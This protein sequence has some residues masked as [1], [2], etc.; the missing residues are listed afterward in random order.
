LICFIFLFVLFVLFVSFIFFSIIS[1][2]V[3]SPDTYRYGG[4]CI[5]HKCFKPVL[6]F[7]IKRGNSCFGT[8]LCT[9]HNKEF[10]SFACPLINECTIYCEHP[11]NCEKL[12][13]TINEN[14]FY[15]K[16]QCAMH[17]RLKK[18]PPLTRDYLPISSLIQLGKQLYKNQKIVQAI[19][20]EYFIKLYGTRGLRPL[21]SLPG[22]PTPELGASRPLV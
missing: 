13:A 5:L 15:L 18:I 17:Q 11:S 20:N 2:N 22:G 12:I 7:G 9:S 19:E 10:V 21:S 6:N 8:E 14:Y 16:N 3:F 4:V 1:E